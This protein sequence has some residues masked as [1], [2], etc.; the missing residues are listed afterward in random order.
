MDP[1]TLVSPGVEQNEEPE[2][3]IESNKEVDVESTVGM[4]EIDV[5]KME[6]V[7]LQRDLLRKDCVL[8]DLDIEYRTRELVLLNLEIARAE[9]GLRCRRRRR[10]RAEMTETVSPSDGKN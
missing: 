1:V 10:S 4:S 2:A 6:C 9:R 8:R 7:S 3:P 5:A